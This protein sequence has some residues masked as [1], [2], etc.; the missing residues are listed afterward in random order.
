MD[1]LR[2]EPNVHRVKIAWMGGGIMENAATSIEEKNKIIEHCNRGEFEREGTCTTILPFLLNFNK[3]FYPRPR[4]A[5]PPRFVTSRMTEVL[6][7]SEDSAT[8]VKREIK[9]C[10][11]RRAPCISY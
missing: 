11:I 4:G 2:I 5:T 8:G 6:D 9:V 3:T 7:D 10:G 1:T